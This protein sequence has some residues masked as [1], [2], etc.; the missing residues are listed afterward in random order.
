MNSKR[1]LLLLFLLPKCVEGSWWDAI[2]GAFGAAGG[3]LG[4]TGQYIS[5]V[6]ADV[7]LCPFSQDWCPDTDFF[8]NMGYMNV[9]ETDQAIFNN[10]AYEW[11]KVLYRGNLEPIKDIDVEQFPDTDC[12]PAFPTEIDDLFICTSYKEDSVATASNIIGTAS[13]FLVRSTGKNAP[14]PAVGR[15]YINSH[16]RDFVELKDVAVSKKAAPSYAMV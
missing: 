13:P 1:F 8:I 14:L 9:S 6:F 10:S 15:I 5:S 2:G 12:N 3:F 4:D 7:F 11:V 16:L